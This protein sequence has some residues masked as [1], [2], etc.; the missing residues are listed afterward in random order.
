MKAILTVTMVLGLLMVSMNVDIAAHEPNEAGVHIEAHEQ[1]NI[2]ICTQNLIAIGKAIQAYQKENGDLPEWLSDLHPKYLAD[3]NILICPSDKNGGK[4]LYAANVDPKMS[5]SYGYQFHP[6]YQERKN[7][8]RLI[9]GDGVPLVRCR[10][11]NISPMIHCLNLNFAYK[12]SQSISFWE[13]APEQLYDTPE[14]AITALETGIQKQPK[15]ERLSQFVYPSLAS[16]YIKV[17]SKEK[18]EDLISLYKSIMNSDD[19]QDAITLGWML[20]M[21]NRNE[22]AL[23]LYQKLEEKNPTDHNVLRK[24]GEIHEKLGNAELAKEYLLKVEPALAY[25][26]NVVPDFSATDLDGNPISLQ[27]YRGKVVLL[28]FWAV[29]CG[30]CIEEMPNVKK[31]YDTYKDEGFEVIGVSLDFEETT[32]RDYIKENDIPWRQIFDMASGADSLA[33]QYGI[34]GIPAPWLIDRDGKLI[35]HNARGHNLEKFV[36]EAVKN[37]PANE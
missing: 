1:E 31:V 27:D 26:G 2:E 7:E 6:A 28:D 25:V 37:T 32:L 10:H 11:H 18:V 17:G 24:L 19:T 3:S 14:A 36:S 21:I 12:V 35:S 20:E 4:A 30:P 33:K 29:W 9:Y 8:D 16:L 15:S 23:Q 5:V 34:R 22:E 13:L